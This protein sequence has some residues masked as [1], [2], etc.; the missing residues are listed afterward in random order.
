MMHFLLSVF[1][2]ENN[3]VKICV[4]QGT[5]ERQNRICKDYTKWYLL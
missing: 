5:P 4:S 3:S 2:N 1:Y